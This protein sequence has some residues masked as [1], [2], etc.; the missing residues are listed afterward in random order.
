MAGGP[1]RVHTVA[2]AG[3]LTRHC[4]CPAAFGTRWVAI[5]N[6]DGRVPAPSPPHAWPT[7]RHRHRRNPNVPDPAWPPA[8]VA[9]RESLGGSS[10][11]TARTRTADDASR[12]ARTHRQ[13]AAERMPHNDKFGRILS[14]HNIFGVR[15]GWCRTTTVASTATVRAAQIRR[16]GSG[17]PA[18]RQ[19]EPPTRLP[20]PVSP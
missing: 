18:G 5:R 7:V 16:E 8:P 9:G 20:R 17:P 12:C 13:R 6:R 19:P 3:A 11:M 14:Y 1:S 15:R 10:A 2:A 4:T